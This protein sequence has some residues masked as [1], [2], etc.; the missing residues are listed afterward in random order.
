MA[1]LTTS[2][3]TQSFGAF[4]LF[5]GVSVSIPND[6]KVGLVGPNGIG[7][8]TLLQILAGVSPPSSG[9]VHIS[10][11]TRLGYLSQ[12]AAQTFA[13]R[14][15]SVYE[16]MLVVFAALRA[17][18][19]RL[20]QLEREMETADP[21]DDLFAQYSQL[22]E[23]FELAGGY[24]Y[25]IQIKQVL[26][27]LGFTPDDWDMPLTHLSGGQ[28]TRARLARLLLEGPELLI[29]DEPTNH[30]DIAA[31]EWL[32]GTLQKWP[33]A[34]LI[35]SHD[36]YF[37]DKVVNVIWEMGR[38]GIETF[39]GNYSA[40]LM[41]REER[42]TLRET[43][44]NNLKERLEKEMDFIRRNIAGQRTQMAQGK[45]SRLTREVEAIHK[46]GLA[47]IPKLNKGWA[48]LKDEIGLNNVPSYKVGELH[49]R[50]QALRGPIRPL[51]LNLNLTTSHR[52]GDLVLR[53]KELVIGYPGTQLFTAD[54]IELRRRECAALIGPNGAGKSTFLKTILEQ[55]ASLAGKVELGASL[56]I[57]YFSQAHEELNRDNEVLDELLGFENMPISEAR[58]YLAR[59]LFRGDDV[60]KRV[61]ML[62][63]GERGRLA[64][65]RLELEQA[66]FLLLD[67]PT[68]HLDIP[69]Q[70]A[71]QVVLENFDGTILLVSHDRYLVNRL[72]TQVWVLENGRLHVYRYPYQEYLTEREREREAD[73]AV[74]I[75]KPVET[76]PQPNGNNKLS[77][78]EQRRRQE[79][80]ADVE[81]KIHA[82]E[83]ALRQLTDDLQAATQAESF[84][85]IQTISL[86]YAAT[87][88]KLADL[89]EQWEKLAHE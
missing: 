24:Q 75:T 11:N 66:N 13:G 64:L 80:I 46:G 72:A 9:A 37:L 57:G 6:G 33:G 17:D 69:A 51:S 21:P 29:L 70:E 68:N 22:Q 79:A 39:R 52:S 5:S 2:F 28:R 88:E 60:Y 31:I 49:Q 55:L 81:D 71:L 59:F 1:I 54:N 38:E 44:F 32:E 7:K 73:K 67:E 62:S 58:S 74:P 35:V 47:A 77:K 18:E 48:E 36:R 34:V 30:L 65:A 4:D 86:E 83:Q 41:Q 10:R 43:E 12:E 42:W 40:Y 15:H 78:N 19:A 82:A 87:E 76:A 56:K 45:L 89:M 8:T 61:S 20:R 63:G 3:I 53:T 84:D 23:Q 26:T 85:K 16:E 14:D 27:G 50:I 25:D